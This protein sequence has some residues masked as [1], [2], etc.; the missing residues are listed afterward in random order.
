V[1][2][3]LR[4]HELGRLRRS[5]T[6]LT[7]NQDYCRTMSP[8]TPSSPIILPVITIDPTFPAAI[9]DVENGILPSETFWISCYRTS[10]QSVHAKIHVELDDDDRNLV[11][12][13]P[14]EGDVELLQTCNGTMV[15]YTILLI[16]LLLD[17]SS[18]RNYAAFCKPLSVP[19]TPLI[20][21][22][23]KYLDAERSDAQRVSFYLSWEFHLIYF[24]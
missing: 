19:P 10:H 6:G 15:S 20:I 21:P 17:L 22:T 5:L 7:C 3:I 8:S 13:K 18:Q 2:Q 12:L 11:H 24:L 9:Q 16:E 23:Q 14:R 1:K 4:A